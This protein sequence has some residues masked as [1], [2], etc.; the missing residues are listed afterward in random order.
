[1]S[2]KAS[3]ARKELQDLVEAATPTRYP[4]NRFMR[5]SV[6]LEQ[7]VALLV[8]LDRL[9]ELVDMLEDRDAERERGR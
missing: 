9:N 4:V 2:T 3:E 7:L 5:V 1:M 8:E 6:P